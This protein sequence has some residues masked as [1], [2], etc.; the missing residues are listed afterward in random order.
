MKHKLT[1]EFDNREALEH[2]A[3]WLCGQG[4]QNYW[5]WMEYREQEEDGDITAS[6]D[7]FHE[8]KFLGDDTIRASCSRLDKDR[9]K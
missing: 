7:Y 6:F 2:F 8:K 9:F 1:I 4:E 3:H 5:L